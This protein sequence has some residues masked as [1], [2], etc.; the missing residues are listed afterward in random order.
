MIH[1]KKVLTI[2]VA[3][4]M[5]C[6]VLSLAS[7]LQVNAQQ[8]PI[9]LVVNGHPL[10]NLSMPPVIRQ[11]RMLV[12]ARAVFE[13]LG[14]N[15]QWQEATRT[16]H[17]QYQEQ[18]VILTI[19]QSNIIV[20]GYPQEMPIPAQIINYNTMIPVGAVATNLGFLVDFRDRTVFVNTPEP[21]LDFVYE[22]YEDTWEHGE[23][24]R[25][26]YEVADTYD[27]DEYVTDEA[28]D[29]VKDIADEY[30]EEPSTIPPPPANPLNVRYDFATRTLHIPK[31]E[32]FPLNIGQASHF[33]LYHQH[34][35]ILWLNVDASQHINLGSLIAGDALLHSIDIAQGTHGTQIVFHGTQILALYINESATDYLIRIMCP[36]EKYPRIVIIDPGHGGER[37][38]AVYHDVR[39]ADLN[40]AVTR[41][42]IQLIEADGFIKAY[43]TRN[44]DI[45]VP[46]A[47]RAR[48]GNEIG[49]LM[50][51]IHHNASENLS[52]HGVETFYLTDEHDQFRHLTNQNFADIVQRNLLAQTG[53]H[54][55]EIKS[56]NFA[57]LRYADIPSALVEIGFMSH[58]HEFTTLINPEYQLRAAR[59]L[60]FALLEAFMWVPQR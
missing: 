48:L 4:L 19:G 16:V 51:T 12:P 50:I 23:E 35:Y 2:C 31:F 39:A 42:L 41:Q 21:M 22:S 10:N 36:R 14:A 25:L 30:E 32:G 8:A 44:S 7:P 58:Q 26:D 45:T 1:I 46:W 18:N 40:L 9:G 29:E 5:G 34:Q 60:Y 52:A 3:V 13:S 24:S 56:G 33:N 15:V 54:D 49:D 37:P 57:V 17:V 27:Q 43:T 11:D 53:R 55:R 38:G 28:D 20:N 6:I 47:D 59:G